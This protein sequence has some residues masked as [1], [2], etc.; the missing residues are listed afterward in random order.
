MN[1]SLFWNIPFVHRYI[2]I[3]LNNCFIYNDIF[4]SILIFLGYQLYF[5]D[6]GLKV[7]CKYRNFLWNT[8]KY[9]SLSFPCIY[10]NYQVR[11]RA[12]EWFYDVCHQVREMYQNENLGNHTSGLQQHYQSSSNSQSLSSSQ[13]SA[14]DVIGGNPTA[15]SDTNNT[16]SDG[17]GSMRY[18]T[19]Y[20]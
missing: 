19:V 14:C 13:T 12:T 9:N 4:H 11:K 15:N 20:L 6:G 1:H 7:A 8:S 18:L 5:L 2:S 10:C 17:H 3:I 16:D